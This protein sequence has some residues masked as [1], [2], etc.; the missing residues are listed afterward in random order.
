M[1]H[2]AHE[3]TSY[4][5]HFGQLD[6]WSHRYDAPLRERLH[7][8][9]RAAVHRIFGR[10]A[11]LQALDS[12]LTRLDP[13]AVGF[14]PEETHRDFLSRRLEQLN[15]RRHRNEQ[16]FFDGTTSYQECYMCENK[17][18]RSARFLLLCGPSREKAGPFLVD[19][20]DETSGVKLAL[21]IYAKVRWEC[22]DGASPKS[23]RNKSLRDVDL[24]SRGSGLRQRVERRKKARAPH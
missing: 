1:A 5:F 12:E 2:H 4:E 24:K 20:N 18:C 16:L 9:L 15:Q 8:K 11:A 23:H 7:N 17:W 3:I 22:S 14:L 21:P 19:F 10:Q 13:S 6:D